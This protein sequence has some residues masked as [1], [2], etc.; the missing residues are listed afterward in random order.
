MKKRINEIIKELKEVIEENN[1][2]VLDNTLFS[3]ALTTYRGELINQN[4]SKTQ[5][6]E[7]PVRKATDKQLAYAQQLADKK[8]IEINITGNETTKEISKLIEELKK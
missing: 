6:E 8:G 1:L 3:E 7:K 2:N 5:E 4:K